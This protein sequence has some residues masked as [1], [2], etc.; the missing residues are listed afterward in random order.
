[1]S[2]PPCG[3]EELDSLM[4]VKVQAPF[5]A[6]VQKVQKVQRVVVGAFTFMESASLYKTFTTG[7]SPVGKQA[8]RPCVRGNAFPLWWLAPPPCPVG[9]M[10]LDSRVAALPYESSFFATPAS[11]GTMDA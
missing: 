1:M 10:S 4:S 3:E 2:L 6:R 7:L 8:S 11:G 9:I 5:G